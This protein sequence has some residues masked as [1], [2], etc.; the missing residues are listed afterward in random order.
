MK[1]DKD[2]LCDLY[3]TQK[4]TSRAIA[5]RYSV[6]HITVLRWMKSYGIERRPSGI[7][8]L[9]RGIVGPDRQELYDM[10]H[11][12]HLGYKGVAAIYGVDQS[13]IRH[14]MI[15]HDI[16]RS[17]VWGT[18]YKGKNP[19]L[20][21]KEESI[22]LH[23]Q[24]KSMREIGRMYDVTDKVIGRLFGEYGIE[25]NPDGWDSGKRFACQ[26]GH[27]V[28]STYE[29]KV[30]DWLHQHGIEHVYE[31]ALPCDRRYHSDFLAEGWYIEIWGVLN[32]VTYNDRKQRK[33]AMY[34]AHSMPLIELSPVHF[35]TTAKDRWK[36][37]LMS[38]LLT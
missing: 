3:C 27:L 36:R 6:R 13:A 30:D 22:A 37:I 19:A 26:D 18:R 31:P 2:T 17:T 21:N 15:K 28:R 38:H 4:L 32:N 33:T 7:G 1:P 11:V 34:K 14:W 10:I 16:P 20:P 29:Q 35:A 8:L 12:Q 25:P 23:A 24:G 5:Q 9:S